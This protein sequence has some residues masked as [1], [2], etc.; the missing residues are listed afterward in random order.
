MEF[1]EIK[2]VRIK[3][4]D[5]KEP[6]NDG[7]PRSALYTIP[8]ELSDSPPE[9]WINLFIHTW[10]N[11]PS[12]T[13]MH[14]PRIAE[15]YGKELLLNGTTIEE[16]EKYHHKT[17]KLVLNKVNQEIKDYFNKIN[18]EEEKE[19]KEKILKQ[20]ELNKKLDDIVDKLDFD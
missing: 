16:Y 13:S 14:R 1:K 6:A 7:S 18:A 2:I 4:E 12:F 10:D 3:K 5:I 19:R 9:E 11:P 15:V 17:L 20:E 8:F